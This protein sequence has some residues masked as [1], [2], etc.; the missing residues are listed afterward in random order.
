MNV[1]KAPFCIRSIK[2]VEAK[3]KKVILNE[4]TVLQYNDRIVDA[5]KFH[6]PISK[7]V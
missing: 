1:T 2:S 6:K 7:I 5:T 3:K 4:I